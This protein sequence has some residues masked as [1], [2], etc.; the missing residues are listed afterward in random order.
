GGLL[1]VVPFTAVL[2]YADARL[3]F[4]MED[5]VGWAA[6]PFG[7]LLAISLN[8]PRHLFL[9]LLLPDKRAA[10]TLAGTVGMAVHLAFP[11]IGGFGSVT[12][13]TL[14]L[15]WCVLLAA[16]WTPARRGQNS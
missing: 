7:L 9:A 13:I 3:T 1:A 6:V 8:A 14:A 4:D 2:T 12:Y 11:G 10:R 16:L 5:R 15:L